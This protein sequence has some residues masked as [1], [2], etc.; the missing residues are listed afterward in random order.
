M[1]DAAKSV[2]EYL[3]RR[4]MAF[5]NVANRLSVDCDCDAHPHEPEMAD[6]GVFASLDPVALD[7]ACV[8]A[9]YALSLI[10]IYMCIRDSTLSEPVMTRTPTEMT[11]LFSIGTVMRTSFCQKLAPSIS[12]AS[13]TSLG[14]VPKPAK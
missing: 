1:A 10:H 14:M 6:I 3:G 5:I 8:D 12:A 13:N 4:N 11:V 7:Q 2:V 9:V